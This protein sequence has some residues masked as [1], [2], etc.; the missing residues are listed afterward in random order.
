MTADDMQKERDAARQSRQ[1][2][3]RAYR[4][5]KQGKDV[6]EGLNL[7]GGLA[8]KQMN[9]VIAEWIRRAES[10]ERLFQQA[11]AAKRQARR[12]VS[13]RWDD[14]DT[15]FESIYGHRKRNLDAAGIAF[16]VKETIKAHRVEY[17]RSRDAQAQLAAARQRELAYLEVVTLAR[18]YLSTSFT[19]NRNKLQA[20]LDALAAPG[21]PT[22]QTPH[23][24]GNKRSG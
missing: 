9:D 14:L 21:T 19:S 17:A 8:V 12:D 18:A 15:I 13:E 23:A 6:A 5:A 2:L 7:V 11:N 10:A 4:I 16:A 24:L 1:R 3:V 20:A 22:E